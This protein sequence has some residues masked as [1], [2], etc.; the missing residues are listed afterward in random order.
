MP[1]DAVATPSRNGPRPN[2]PPSDVAG[3]PRSHITQ[4]AGATL[5]DVVETFR[6]WLLMPDPGGLHFALA[7]V[8][9][10]WLGGDPVW[11][12]LVASPAGSKTEIIRSLETVP[13]VYPLS[14]LT[15]RTFASGLQNDKRDPSLLTRLSDQ[16]LTL[17]DFGTVLTMHREERQAILSQLREIFDGRFDKAWGTGKE[18]HWQGRLGFLAGVTPIIDLHHAVHQVLGE[19]FVLYRM[20]QPDRQKMAQQ[21]LRGRGREGEM[22]GEMRST[23]AS[24]MASLDYDHPPSLPIALETRLAALADLIT[25]ARSGVVR[26]RRSR[27]LELAPDPEGPARLV[28]QLAG[29]TIGHAFIRGVT[30]VEEADYALACKVALDCLPQIRRKVFESLSTEK[31]SLTTSKVAQSIKYPTTTTRRALEDFAALGVAEVEK[32]GAGHADSWRLSEEAKG[33][34]ERIA[35]PDTQPAS[36]TFPATSEG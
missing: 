17:K 26:D 27:D 32:G 29:L 9:G 22:R 11:G 33:L 34:L 31:A 19:R 13:G 8:A 2:S 21:A 4:S 10:H 24:F 35:V 36:K 16:V 5:A 30:Q 7:V 18:M 23:V 1:V 6:R 3:K 15:A 20:P 28:K 25:R 12:L 14:D